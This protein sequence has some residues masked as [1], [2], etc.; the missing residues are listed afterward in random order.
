VAIDL[1]E[2]RIAKTKGYHKDGEGGRFE[3]GE[4]Q[5]EKEE[6]EMMQVSSANDRD[7]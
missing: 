7:G 3:K 1:T 4:G 2:T 6:E 5:G